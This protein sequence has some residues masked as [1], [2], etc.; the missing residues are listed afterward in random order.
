MANR[1]FEMQDYRKAL[2]GMRQ[3]ESDRALAHRGL[4]E[5]SDSGFRD[6]QII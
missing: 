1:R 6:F 4:M 5:L 2:H 3:G